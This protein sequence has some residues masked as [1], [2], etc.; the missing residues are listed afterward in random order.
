MQKILLSIFLLAIFLQSSV[1]DDQPSLVIEL[2]RH[3]ARA[4]SQ[5]I[6]PT[7]KE[8]DEL[9][10][11]GIRQHFILGKIVAERYSHLLNEYDTHS[12]Y[13]RSTNYNR[14]LMSVLSQ[15]SGIF[16]EKGK[17]LP[18]EASTDQM[19]PPFADED[20]LQRIADELKETK[21]ALPNK[22]QPIP[23]HSVDLP[24]DD[25]LY[26]GPGNCAN[27]SLW[28]KQNTNNED[29]QK[30]YETLETTTKY[31]KEQGYDLPQ[32]S[33]YF[34]LADTVIANRFAN[35]PLAKGVTYDD[36][37][38]KDIVFSYNWFTN[39]VYGGTGLQL[40]AFSYTLTKQILQ[41]LNDKANDNTPLN[42]ILLSAHDTTLLRLLGLYDIVTPDC[43]AKNQESRKKEEPEPF[44][45]CIYPS[46]ASQIFLEFYNPEG[47]EPYVK[48]I[49][50]SNEIDI[51]KNKQG[52]CT[53]KEF[54][55]LTKSL[56]NLTEEEYY[57]ICL[58]PERSGEV[59]KI[60]LITIV[61]TLL[62]LLGLYAAYVLLKKRQLR[63]QNEYIRV[64][65]E[66][67]AET[68]QI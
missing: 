5:E 53:L 10:E 65:K 31:L 13:V 17:D 45:E 20:L 28:F 38:Y 22:H 6:D 54:E 63:E 9:T 48:F 39:Y 64:N 8:H 18:E 16:Y 12:F 32:L 23:V 44:P 30:I 29:T 59:I 15:L 68:N 21:T 14:T 33:D 42:F 62:I 24:T 41:W 35:K 56:V 51:C 26:S 2:L 40:R 58:L 60:I 49:Y 47:V 37:Y 43:L 7:W 27:S 57:Q 67:S 55:T 4:P 46:Y 1:A 25:L 50:N 11:V 3:G 34:V 36:Q 61:I 66:A 52:K 19:M